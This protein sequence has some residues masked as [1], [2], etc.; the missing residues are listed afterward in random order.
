MSSLGPMSRIERDDAIYRT[1]SGPAN[2]GVNWGRRV[3]SDHRSPAYQAGALPLGYYGMGLGLGIEP[4][5][6]LYGSSA[7]PT[8][9]IQHIQN[10]EARERIELS[11][12]A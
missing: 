10:M 5:T 12:R 7:L 3:E 11:F 6:L 4:R 8:T 1:A 2:T 9:P